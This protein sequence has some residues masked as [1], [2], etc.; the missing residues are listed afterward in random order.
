MPPQITD[1]NALDR[2]RKRALAAPVDFLHEVAITE[3]HERLELVNNPLERRAI[4]GWRGDLWGAAFPSAEIVSDDDRLALPQGLDCVIHAMSLHWSNDP[5][6]QLIQCRLALRPD[7]LLLAI[8][9]G[10]ETLRELRTALAMA[11]SDVT[12]G[13]SP[14]VLPMGEVRDLGALL[15]RAGFAL[16]VAD[17]VRFEVTY[18]NAFGLMKELRAMGEANALTDRLR[19]PTRSGVLERAAEIYANE[20]PAEDGRIR[21]TFEFVVLTGWAPHDSQPKPLRPGS[22]VARLADALGTTEEKL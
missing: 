20:F 2:Q 4:V 7:G 12:G 8:F 13:L 1:R 5:V 18:A 9:P 14:R 22:A 15:Q 3:V 6:G 11:E 19:K 10:G 17:L 21:A 16:P